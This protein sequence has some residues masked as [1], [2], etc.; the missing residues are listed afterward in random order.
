MMDWK[1]RLMRHEDLPAIANVECTALHI[2]KDKAR[3]MSFLEVALKNNPNGCFVGV[4]GGGVV[5]YVVTLITG[6]AGWIG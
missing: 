1:I 4:L 5:G 2:S 3:N 6:N